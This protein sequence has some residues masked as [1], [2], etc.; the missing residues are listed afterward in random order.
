MCALNPLIGGGVF[1]LAVNRRHAQLFVDV[2]DAALIN[3]K[4]S[5]EIMQIL[6]FGLVVQ[7]NAHDRHRV[8]LRHGFWRAPFLS[9][10]CRLWP[11]YTDHFFN[12]LIKLTQVTL[13]LSESSMA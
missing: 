7:I 6:R 5:G 10:C 8:N 9:C 12:S 13:T 2:I 11:A 1:N 3:A 4:F